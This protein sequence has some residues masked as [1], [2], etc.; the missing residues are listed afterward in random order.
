MSL[1]LLL[2]FLLLLYCIARGLSRPAWMLAGYLQTVFA[3]P[4]YWW[5]G[6][7]VP[8]VA[9]FSW[10]LWLGVLVIVS[11]LISGPSKHRIASTTSEKICFVCLVLASLNVAWVHFFFA[12]SP[13]NSYIHADIFWKTSL[14]LF[15]FYK[16]IRNI[17]DLMLILGSI[18]V[19][20]ASI[21]YQVVI[22]KQGYMERGRLEGIAI[23]GASDSNLISGILLLGLL[24]GGYFTL[25]LPK[26][27][28]RV[29]PFSVR[30]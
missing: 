5:W 1:T 27:G 23:P 24:I 16:A 20:C 3:G 7:E 17:D 15:L 18:F 4:Q 28:R 2:W 30:Y 10:S 8:T 26:L 19:G 21:G 11:L 29:W 6:K 9:Q 14:L 25:T 22:G 13:E 12:D